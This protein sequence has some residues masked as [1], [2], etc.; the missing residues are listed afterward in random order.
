MNWDLE[1]ESA[2]TASGQV[3][4]GM[5]KQNN[6]TMCLPRRSEYLLTSTLVPMP[7]NPKR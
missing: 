6:P 2:F 1:S 3:F 4:I 7:L 5:E